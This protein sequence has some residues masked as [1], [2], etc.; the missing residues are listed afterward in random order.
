MEIWK[1]IPGYEGFYEASNLGRIKSVD[2]IIILKDKLG[3]PRPC[4]FKGKVLKPHYC[5]KHGNGLPRQQV[6]ISIKGKR[7]TKEVHALVASTFL[8]CPNQTYT[9]NH[10]D[11]DPLNN[12]VDNLEWISRAD[13]VRHAFKN[14]LIKTMKPVAMCDP[15]SMAV[16]KVFPGEAEACRRFGLLQGKIRRAIQMG[17]KCRGY[18][19]KYYNEGTEGSTTIEPWLGFSR[20]V[21]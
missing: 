1:P 18:V 17:W 12:I 14:N 13:N 6:V 5:P 2:R 15:V 19:W 11:G 21:E 9:V 16:L 4:L 20:V 7:C 10:K 3:N 8:P